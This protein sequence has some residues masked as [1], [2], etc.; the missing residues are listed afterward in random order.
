M[1][2]QAETLLREAE[3]VANQQLHVA[4]TKEGLTVPLVKLETEHVATEKIELDSHGL[5]KPP[6]AREV[7]SS[8]TLALV[9]RNI[10]P[11]DL[12]KLELLNEFYEWLVS[13]AGFSIINFTDLPE[14]TLV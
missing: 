10:V 7:I 1:R 9:A 3:E 4:T 8:F 14:L 11:R 5:E 6:A 12:S 2:D 13:D